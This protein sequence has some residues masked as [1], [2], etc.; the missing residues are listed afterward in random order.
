MSSTLKFN[1]IVGM[2]NMTSGKVY[3]RL[4][5]NLPF[6]Q[7]SKQS[8]MGKGKGTIKYLFCSVNVCDPLFELIGKRVNFIKMKILLHKLHYKNPSI[9]VKVDGRNNDIC[10]NKSI[11]W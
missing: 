1:K 7:K 6:T 11:R 8:R 9:L 3:V 2:S 4:K 5:V 10:R